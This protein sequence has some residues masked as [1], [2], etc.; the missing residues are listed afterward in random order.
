MDSMAGALSAIA[1]YINDPRLPCER[2]PGFGNSLR[3]FG[4][5][6]RVPWFCNTGVTDLHGGQM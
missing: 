4:V 3:A 5:K 2:V 1:V 6:V